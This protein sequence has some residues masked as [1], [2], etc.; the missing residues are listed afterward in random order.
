MP[1]V[2]AWSE[3]LRYL[4]HFQ[5]SSI[6]STAANL[7]LGRVTAR[8]LENAPLGARLADGHPL[9]V[10]DGSDYRSGKRTLCSALA[11]TALEHTGINACQLSYPSSER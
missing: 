3:L 2:N 11:D 1:K 9:H 10:P 5:D 7:T 8:I 4:T 6:T